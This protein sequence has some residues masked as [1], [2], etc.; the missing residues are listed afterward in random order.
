MEIL[1]IDIGGSGIK[2]GL[3]NVETG[4]LV[5]ERLRLNTPQ[6][7]TPKAVA[8]TVEA[9]VKQFAWQGVIGC[10]FPA[11]MRHGVAH[12][13]A[14]VD[15]AWIGTNAEELIQ[16]KTG[17]PTRVI[18]DADA[19]GVAEMSFGAGRG[20]QGVV[21]MLT[22]GT[23]I[24]SAIFLDGKLLP[25]TELGHLEIGG[26]VAEHKASDRVREEE[27]LSWKKW[28]RRLNKYLNHVQFL[29]SPD[30]FI[31]GGGVSKRFELFSP[32]LETATPVVA[33]KLK[34]DA[35]IVGAAMAAVNLL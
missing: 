1:G 22:I 7:A 16:R 14:N 8:S 33:A 15:S 34:N 30:L 19:A 2:G 27:E 13:A 20:V 12:S 3:V 18:N 6:P 5:G 17:N 29:F 31:V 11:I 26:K 25:N 21:V 32:Y 10:T 23:G 24:G 4:E 28:G 35:G 9:L